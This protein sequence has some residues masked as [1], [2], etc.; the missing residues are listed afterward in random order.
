MAA[1]YAHRPDYPSALI[2]RLCGL[3]RGPARVL[4]AGCGPGKL[5]RLLAPRVDAVHAVDAS[6]AMI[7]EG[8]RLA[9]GDVRADRIA[10]AVGRL[11]EVA[12]DPPYGLAVAGAA[13][14]WFDAD[15]VLPRLARA[16]AP[17]AVLALVEGDVAHAPPWEDAVREV[18]IEAVARMEGRRPAWVPDDAS[19]LLAHPRFALEGRERIGPVAVRQPVADYIACQHARATFTPEVMGPDGMRAFDR[20]L[21]EVLAPDAGRDGELRFEVWTRLE[22]GRPTA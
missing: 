21:Q 20:A 16:L 2:D 6:P 18:M 22:W 13:V 5:A 10:W 8:R 3:V 12:L 14:H 9:G 4:D 1:L 7:A 11:E 19:P 15:R 17:G